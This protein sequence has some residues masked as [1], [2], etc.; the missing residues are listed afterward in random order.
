MENEYDGQI[1]QVSGANVWIG[2]SHSDIPRK[3]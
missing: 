2:I 1:T 3:K